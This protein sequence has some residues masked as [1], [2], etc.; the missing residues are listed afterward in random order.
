[1]RIGIVLPTRG[2]FLNDGPPD[3]A[4]LTRQ[5]QRAEALGID[6][7]WCGDSLT[8]KP[9]LEPLTVLAA[10]G[11]STQRIGLG[12]SV[13]LAPLR[14]PVALAQT[15]ATLQLLSGGRLSL[16]IGV[17]G[18]FNEA[19]QGEW[20]AA[21]VSPAGRGARTTEM[22]ELM[23]RLWTGERF[24]YQ[25]RHFQYEDVSIGYAAGPAPPRLLPACHSGAAT[26]AQYGRAARLG[27]GLMS[28]TDSPEEFALVRQRVLELVQQAGRDVESFTSTMYMTINLNADEA[29]AQ[30]EADRFVRGYYGVNFWGERWGPFG[31]PE[32]V[33]ARAMAY[34]DVGADEIVFRF[35]SF[36][37]EG[38]LELF[39][40]TLLPALR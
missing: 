39:A 15:T 7:V 1:M 34:R 19:Q 10:I 4:L 13:L 8:A 11:A 37:Q 14:N 26:S 5:A 17:G 9:R 3:I 23:R 38:Q 31:D 33:L 36:D 27:D 40:R 6:G 25:G 16:G 24:A 20:L 12:T 2:I 21:G 29:A 18:T 35:A 32:R 28:I 30:A 22:L